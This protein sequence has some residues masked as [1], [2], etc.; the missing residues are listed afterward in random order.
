M[1]AGPELWVEG[2]VGS[3][4]TDCPNPLQQVQRGVGRGRGLHPLLVNLVSFFQH[5][6]GE[7]W[8]PAQ[9][10]RFWAFDQTLYAGPYTPQKMQ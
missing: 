7:K 6:L 3:Y 1:G 5:F 8:E 2:V 9:W 10:G 4:G